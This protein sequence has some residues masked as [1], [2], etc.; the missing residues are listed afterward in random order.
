MQIKEM[1]HSSPTVRAWEFS[2]PVD[3][4]LQP[5]IVFESHMAKTL[6]QIHAEIDRLKKQADALREK[7]VAGVI[8]RIQDAIAHYDLTPADLFGS[9]KAPKA[10]K[11]AP[12]AKKSRKPAAAKKTS[13][14]KYRDEATGKTWTGVGKR[15]TWFKEA[16]AA[17][18]TAADLEIKA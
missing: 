14:P 6:A 15:P 1:T 3:S 11:K 8:A 9:T 13:A 12:A 4:E 2:R 5:A 18:K 16:L 10:G 7:E 17:G